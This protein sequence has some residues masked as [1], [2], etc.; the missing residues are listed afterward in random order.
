[1]WNIWKERALRVALL[2]LPK[3][4]GTSLHDY[5]SGHFTHDATCPERFR[6]FD[7]F[8]PAQLKGYDYFSAHMDYA[9]LRRIP[10]PVYTITILREPKARILSLYY[11]WRSHTWETIEAGKLTGPRKAKELGLLDFLRTTTDGIPGNIDNIYVRSLLGSYWA[12]P[13]GRLVL[14][15]DEALRVAMRNL[16]T[17]DT[18]GFMED[19]PGLFAEVSQRTGFEM[20][21][22]LPWARSSEKFG[23]EAGSEKV[24]REVITPEIDR[25]LN[26]L[27]RVDRIFYENARRLF[28]C[29]AA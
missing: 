29:Q 7:R 25:R 24:E 8:T 18:V 4:G 13:R 9:A 19:M 14:S 16:L 5:L 15:D 23:T 10:R 22:E 12:G 2:H 11:F 3:T 17:I 20:P 1:M 6:N 27:T 21:A 28:G 26:H